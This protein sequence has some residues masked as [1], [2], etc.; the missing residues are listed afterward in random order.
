MKEKEIVF[1]CVALKSEQIKSFKIENGSILSVKLVTGDV[2][3]Q[4]YSCNE[5]AAKM[6]K[7]IEIFTR[8]GE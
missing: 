3:M 5:R 1:C 8:G 2:L 6:F 7:K 4:S